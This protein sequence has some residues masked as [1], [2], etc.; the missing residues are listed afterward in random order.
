LSHARDKP[1]IPID[2]EALLKNFLTHLKFARRGEALA[3]LPNST[4]ARIKYIDLAKPKS[5]A[6]KE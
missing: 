4:N 6:A 3:K 1:N 5:G 2:I